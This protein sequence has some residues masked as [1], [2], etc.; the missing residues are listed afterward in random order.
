MGVEGGV[1]E[2]SIAVST[3]LALAGIALES[4]TGKAAKTRITLAKKAKTTDS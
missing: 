4:G 1:E 2:A 3:A